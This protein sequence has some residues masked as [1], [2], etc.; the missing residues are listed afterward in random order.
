MKASSVIDY[1]QILLGDEHGEYHT[2]AK[3]LL[4]LNQ[5]L[6]DVSRRSRSLRRG[7]YYGVIAG[8]ASYGLPADFLMAEPIG[9]L[10]AGEWIDLRPARFQSQVRR[11]HGTREN[12]SN[13]PL[14]Y[15]V[16]QRSAE[17]RALGTVTWIPDVGDADRNIL[18]RTDVSIDNIKIGDKLINITDGSEGLVRDTMAGSLDNNTISFGFMVNGE[19]NTFAV[20]DEFRVVSQAYLAQTIDITPIPTETDETGT[21]SLYIYYA[22]EHR[23]ITSEDITNE[24]DDLEIDVEFETPTRHLLM[25]LAKED[26]FGAASQETQAKK[27]DYEREYINAN[28]KVQRRIREFISTWK[29][30]ASGRYDPVYDVTDSYAGHPFGAGVVI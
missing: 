21:E 28:T 16:N 22:F 10:H 5:A 4:H 9:F 15:S 1:A 23:R 12:Y 3:M 7:I 11:I 6:R 18:F 25:S 27:L 29:T 2:N 14:Y 20:D 19:D 17:E 26:E 24:A 30:R 8:Q 13:V